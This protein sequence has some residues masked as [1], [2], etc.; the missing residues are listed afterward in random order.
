MSREVGHGLGPLKKNVFAAST[1]YDHSEVLSTSFAI[2]NPKVLSFFLGKYY[3]LF[4][5][6]VL[7]ISYYTEL[8]CYL[9]IIIFKPSLEYNLFP[10]EEVC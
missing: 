3:S 10:F 9:S 1:M 7:I 6:V 2:L 8:F 4:T 5:L